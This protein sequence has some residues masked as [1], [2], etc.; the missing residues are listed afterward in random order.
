MKA[1]TFQVKLSII[2]LYSCALMSQCYICLIP[3]CATIICENDF[4]KTILAYVK[5]C[6]IS[7]Y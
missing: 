6:A 3:F 7:F 5:C 2:D 1:V 4:S